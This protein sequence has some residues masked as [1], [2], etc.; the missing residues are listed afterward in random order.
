LFTHL[1]TNKLSY[2]DANIIN[3]VTNITANSGDQKQ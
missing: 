2:R 3:K 1:F